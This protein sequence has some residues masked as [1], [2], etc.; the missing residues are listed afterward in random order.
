MTTIYSEKNKAIIDITKPPYNA[1]NTGVSDCTDAIKQA[2]D[3]ILRPNIAGL[4]KAKQKL[5]SMPDPNAKI[6]FEIRKEN[7]VLYVIFPEELEDSKIIYFPKGTYLVSDTVSYTL[8]N[9]SNIYAGVSKY[10]MNRQIHF[11]GEARE[12]VTIKLK[13][14]CKGFEYGSQ[15][16]VVSFMQ[17]ESS[18]LSMTNSFEDITIDIGRNNPGAVGL[19]FF[20]NN[21]GTVKNVSIKSSDEAKRGYAG[22]H[23]KHEIVSGC[24]VKN[25]EV[26]GFD[27]GVRATPVRNFS[28]FENIYISNQRKC[29][30][31]VDNM[32]IS[33]RNLQSDNFVN[34]FR[35]N[36]ALTHAVL[37]DSRLYG[38]NI[39]ESA[40]DIGSGSA[41]VRSV[42]TSGYGSSL[43]YAL[44]KKCEGRYID[45]YVSDSV[46]TVFDNELKS[47]P[48]KVLDMPEPECDLN[49]ESWISVNDFGA[50]GDGVT[51]DTKAIQ[52]ALSSG[53]SQIFFQ[54]GK[55]LVDG[56]VI[57]PES[58]NRI[59]FMF[60]DFVSGEQLKEDRDNG[61]FVITGD[62]G[63]IVLENVFTWE[64]F[65]GYMRFIEHRGKRTLS[66]I[67]LHTQTAA[68]YFNSVEGGR[69]FIENCGCTVGGFGDSPYRQITAYSFKG[70]EVWARH[71]NPERSFCEILND[72]GRVWIMGFKTEN[73]GTAFKTINGGHTEVLGGTISIGCNKE[74]PAIVNENSTVSVVAA[75]NGYSMNDLFPIAVRETQGQKTGELMS[76]EFP[77]R[78]LRCYKIPLYVGRA[79]DSD[80][81]EI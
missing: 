11:K 64:R 20:G 30:F 13:D 23:I 75:T 77:L 19:V 22:L 43:T 32:I 29:G 70:Q 1:D 26:D 62:K 54:P 2:M 34:A 10:E 27:Y 55:Y 8:E 74:L 40:V 78:L 41:F 4:E 3:D 37:V 53:S 76:D 71:I 45:E 36:G 31:F 33:V 21:T 61:L 50:V 69:V 6:S 73:Y 67:N 12:L 9:L 24:Y 17:A 28:V 81:G 49:I 48:L 46:H 60:C 16:P 14:N 68:M 44:E 47:E 25:L 79:G 51:D 63:N 57:V 72:G 65:H 7:N 52:A 15:K 80:G 18:N 58:V 35:I 5:L 42:D 38:G 66:M 56:S 59:N 39:L